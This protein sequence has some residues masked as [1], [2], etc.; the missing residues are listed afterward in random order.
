MFPNISSNI[1]Y[2]SII[3]SEIALL[4]LNV[5]LVVVGIRSSLHHLCHIRKILA[6]VEFDWYFKLF[7]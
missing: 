1:L 3:V 4:L 2:L 6:F 5:L 7:K